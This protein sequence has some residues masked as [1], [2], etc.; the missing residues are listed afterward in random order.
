MTKRQAKI[1]IELENNIVQ[2]ERGLNLDNKLGVKIDANSDNRWISSYGQISSKRQ[3]FK[4][5][6]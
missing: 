2:K 1:S 4:K 5:W 6:Q 3:V